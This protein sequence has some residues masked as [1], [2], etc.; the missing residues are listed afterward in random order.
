[1]T[2]GVIQ[3]IYYEVECR[4]CKSKFHAIEGTKKY[5]DYKKNRKGKLSCDDCDR[6]IEADSR[7]YLFNRD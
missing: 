3:L 1:M 4:Y 6:K 5:A 7:K 2:I